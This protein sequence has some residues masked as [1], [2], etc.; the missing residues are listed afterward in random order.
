MTKTVLNTILAPKQKPF[1][2]NLLKLI[3]NTQIDTNSI[4]LD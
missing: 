2:Y 1:K 4:D 3:Q